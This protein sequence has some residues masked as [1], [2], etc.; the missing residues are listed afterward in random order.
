VSA[1]WINVG[2]V[3]STHELIQTLK[4]IFRTQ[5][6]LT[7]QYLHGLVPGNGGDFLVAKA[8]LDQAGDDFVAQVVETQGLQ[9]PKC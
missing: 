7:P 2:A 4:Q 8:D 3:I 9:L 5:V 6:S 1:A